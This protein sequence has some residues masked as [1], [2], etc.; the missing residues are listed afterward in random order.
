MQKGRKKIVTEIN[1]N[2]IEQTAILHVK[3]AFTT[4]ECKAVS[5]AVMTY[6]NK[7]P[8]FDPNANLGCWRGWPHVKGGFTEEINSMII[9]RCSEAINEYMSNLAKPTNTF[10]EST[11][12][13]DKSRYVFDAWFNVNRKGAENREHSHSGF[14]SKRC[15]I[16][17]SN[18]YRSY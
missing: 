15:C 2:V 8:S 18:G 11:E 12:Y 6:K 17:S 9:D 7:S 14:F 4:E 13:L 1:F 3:Q 10:G 16:F 5:D